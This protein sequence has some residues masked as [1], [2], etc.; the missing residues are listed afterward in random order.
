VIYFRLFGRGFSIVALTAMNVRQIA[1]GAYGPAFIVGCSISAV[2]WF[3]S[4]SAAHSDAPAAWM[5]YS[6]G[7][8]LGTVFGMWFGGLWSR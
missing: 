1:A 4:R 3:N 7:A 6:L 2:W 5:A 8:G